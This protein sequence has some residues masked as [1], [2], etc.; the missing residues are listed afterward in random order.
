MKCS[1]CNGEGKYMSF[2]GRSSASWET[3]PV[4][5]GTGKSFP[6]KQV[7]LK[8]VKNILVND[9]SCEDCRVKPECHVK[10]ARFTN[11][12]FATKECQAT[13]I[14]GYLSQSPL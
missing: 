13:R 6:E 9:I 8:E 4:C 1:E 12:Y 3:C 14:V 7:L 11:D 10:S 5:K 2:D